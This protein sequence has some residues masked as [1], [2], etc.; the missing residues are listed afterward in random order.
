[1]DQSDTDPPLSAL[2][3]RRRR[4]VL[5]CV[6]E[7]NVVT[8]ADLADELAVDEHGATIDG[9]PAAAVTE[10]YL[11]LY[12]H[13]VPTLEDAGLVAYDQ[14]QDLVTITGA[15]TTAHAY[16]EEQVYEFTESRSQPSRECPD[17]GSC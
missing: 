5:A 15:G 12:H 17:E 2:A 9:V 6:R 7:H 16:L 13:H 8:L 10:L 1:M 14:E 3:H 4:A 11:S